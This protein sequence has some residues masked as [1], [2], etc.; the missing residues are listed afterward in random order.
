MFNLGL[1][2]LCHLHGESHQCTVCGVDGVAGGGR[3]SP[4]LMRISH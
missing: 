3:T 1:K 2:L 4:L